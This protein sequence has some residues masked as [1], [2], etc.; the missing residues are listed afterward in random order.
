MI[1]SD[2]LAVNL[3]ENYVNIGIYRQILL[4][5]LIPLSHRQLLLFKS[6]GLNFIHT[7]IVGLWCY[8]LHGSLSCYESVFHF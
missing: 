5:H 8:V 3:I 1:I 4:I 7:Y 2:F 6:F